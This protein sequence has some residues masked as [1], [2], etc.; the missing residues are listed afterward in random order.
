MN[1]NFEIEVKDKLTKLGFESPDPYPY[2]ENFQFHTGNDMRY[3]IQYVGGD[4][5]FI[6]MKESD[7]GK[8][9]VL[10]K[11]FLNTVQDSLSEMV[12]MYISG[13]TPHYVK[14]NKT[15]YFFNSREEFVV[16]AVRDLLRT[17][18]LLSPN[19]NKD[20]YIKYINGIQ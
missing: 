2:P 8:K 13:L 3:L 16:M 9:N 12:G 18:N 7:I 15:T 20:E 5:D 1:N 11:K 6:F 4:P 10:L 14:K 19:I 17:F